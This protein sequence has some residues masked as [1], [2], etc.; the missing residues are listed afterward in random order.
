MIILATAV[1]ASV[2]VEQTWAV[3]PGIPPTGSKFGCV[4]VGIF[5]GIF[6]KDCPSPRSRNAEEAL[7]W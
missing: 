1:H 7:S 6:V 3:L 4:F 2:T 5:V